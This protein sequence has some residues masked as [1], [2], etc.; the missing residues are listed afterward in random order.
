MS[1]NALPHVDSLQAQAAQ[2]AIVP[3]I[4]IQRVAAI[5]RNASSKAPL[6]VSHRQ[7]PTT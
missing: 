4:H 6:I 5:P 1:T 7:R 2:G 3:P